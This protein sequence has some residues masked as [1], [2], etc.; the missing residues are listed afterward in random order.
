MQARQSASERQ[1]VR[2]EQSTNSSRLDDRYGKIGIPA[3][4]AA[5][6][7]RGQERK[8]HRAHQVQRDSD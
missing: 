5:V 1:D 8:T 6:R 7:C 3:V 4:A 2:R